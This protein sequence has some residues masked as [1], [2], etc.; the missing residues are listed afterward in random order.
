MN[1]QL[2]RSQ[3]DERTPKNEPRQ[4]SEPPARVNLDP[5]AQPEEGAEMDEDTMM[6]M[7]G[8]SGF[9][10]TKGKQI[11]GNQ[12]G[13]ASIKKQRTWR[14]YMNRRGGFNRPLDKIK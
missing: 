10:S 14:Q 8:M 9:G 6:A 11:E 4:D 3:D 1:L 7:M 2:G 12:E 5:D 13:A